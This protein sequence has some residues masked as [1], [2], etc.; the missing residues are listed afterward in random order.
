M[1]DVRAIDWNNVWKNARMQRT[2]PVR[3]PS[4]WNKRAPSFAEN[5]LKKGYAEAFVKIVNP[6]KTWSVLDM[7]CGAGILAVPFARHVRSVTA[8]DF[9]E[10]MLERLQERCR[11]TG[12]SNIRILK[13]S[14]ED[15]W[16][17][18]GIGLHDVAIASRSLVVDD[19]RHAVMKLNNIARK[20]VYISTIVDDGPY[21]RR[22]FDAVGRKLDAGPD[23]IYN[24]NLL[25]Q[26]GIHANVCFIT[27]DY[28]KTY[29]D[30]YE[31]L[32]S[33]RWMVGDMTP[34]EE[35]R[36]VDHF[37]KHLVCYAGRWVLD[38]RRTIRWAVIWWDKGTNTNHR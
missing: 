38:Y 18:A 28:Q 15:N 26:M 16:S 4:F 12:I 37:D 7:A 23:Y 14:W 1:K 21:D 29:G 27:E 13:A 32:D 11:E 6:R 36:Y 33:A 3:S 5:S 2:T 31:A 9:S 19:L 20:R 10:A 8:V 35:K 25:Y 17:K 34:E 22:I 30:R 24:Y